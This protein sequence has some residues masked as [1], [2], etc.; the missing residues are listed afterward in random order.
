V[1][2]MVELR[3]VDPRDRVAAAQ[4]PL[5]YHRDRGLDGGGSGALGGTG[6]QEVQPTLLHRELDVLDVAVVPLQPVDGLLELVEGGREGC[7]HLFQRNGQPDSRHHVLALRVQEELAAEA[8][9]ARGGV[10]AEADARPAVVA[11]VP[12]HHLHHVHGGAEV[13]RDLVGLPVHAGS[14]RVPRVE[15][16]AHC[17][18]QLLVGV[19]GEG[20]SGLVQVDLLVALDQEP[21][22]RRGQVD[23]ALDAA[24]GA[25]SHE[26]LLEP[27]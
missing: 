23:V 9:L 15:H 24:L 21:Q 22:V 6:L 25:Q 8:A 10:A 16:R 18:K 13:V 2:E 7:A 17:A 20:M 5:L 1:E 27:V 19:G 11:L 14:R 4:Q 3:R 26:G 12:E